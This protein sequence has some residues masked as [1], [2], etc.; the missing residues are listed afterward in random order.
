MSGAIAFSPRNVVA[1]NLVILVSLCI[2]SA[3]GTWVGTYYMCPTIVREVTGCTDAATPSLVY[4]MLG[5]MSYSEYI[6]FVYS[7]FSLDS[8][9]LVGWLQCS[10]ILQLRDLHHCLHLLQLNRYMLLCVMYCVLHIS[11][12]FMHVHRSFDHFLF[13]LQ[14]LLEYCY[15]IMNQIRM[16]HFHILYGEICCLP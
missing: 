13:L 11:L 4:S 10:R 2:G 9:V 6:I 7:I 16:V 8:I 12:L 5:A 14:D 15:H 3:V 1:L